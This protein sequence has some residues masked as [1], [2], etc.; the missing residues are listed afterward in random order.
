MSRGGR[1]A[2]TWAT[3]NP[4][5]VS[6]NWTSFVLTADVP[7]FF[8]HFDDPFARLF[9][10]RVLRVDNGFVGCMPRPVGPGIQRYS[11]SPWPW[12]RF[13]PVQAV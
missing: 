10:A 5:K 12:D 11:G 7:G 13:I 6:C 3:A 1:N 2:Y 4:D 8:K 9:G